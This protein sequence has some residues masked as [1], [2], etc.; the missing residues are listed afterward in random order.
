MRFGLLGPCGGD[1]PILEQG[2]RLL[3]FEHRADQV[4]YLGPDDALDRLVLDWAGRLVGG[5]ASETGI[6]RRAADHCAEG[7]PDDIAGFVRA[8]RER[9]RLKALRCLSGPAARTIE[10]LEGRVAV[11]LY[12]KALLDEEDI[13]PASLLIFGKSKEPL[14]RHVG[15][16]VFICP[17]ELAAG[18]GGVGLLSTVPTGELD[19]VLLEPGG[20]ILETHSLPAPPR[21]T[22]FRVLDNGPTS[23]RT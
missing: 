7:A 21:S 4:I 15:P 5:D 10:L 23:E 3:L 17:G 8:E 22:R 18:N 13:L 14:V 19:L 11:L 1:L 6:F 20:S 16:R 9:D 12:D 2:A